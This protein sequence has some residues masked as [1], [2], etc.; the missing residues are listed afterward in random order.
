[1]YTAITLDY[2]V[3]MS[4][5]HNLRSPRGNN[6]YVGKGH[7]HIPRSIFF[8]PGQMNK[9]LPYNSNGRENKDWVIEVLEMKW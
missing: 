4:E 6:G 7:D 3:R 1:M 2:K 5:T 9:I 8:L